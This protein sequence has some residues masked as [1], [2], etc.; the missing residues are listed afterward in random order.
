MGLS[1]ASFKNVELDLPVM[2]NPFAAAWIR[3]YHHAHIVLINAMTDSHPRYSQH[4][5]TRY[6]EWLNIPT[7]LFR[8]DQDVPIYTETKLTY[9]LNKLLFSCAFL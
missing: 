5:R 7:T 3:S 9:H 8:A 4:Q 2:T 1:N 6:A